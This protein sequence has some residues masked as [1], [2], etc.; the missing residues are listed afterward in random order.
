MSEVD[1][2]DTAGHGPTNARRPEHPLRARA[3]KSLK[4]IEEVETAF[5]E[6]IALLREQHAEWKKTAAAECELLELEAR[7]AEEG[8]RRDEE[9]NGPFAR[10]AEVRSTR[11]TASEYKG[12]VELPE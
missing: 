8:Q 11:A 4:Y 10:N 9:E 7:A 6:R 2:G 3:R 12:T 5:E 1:N